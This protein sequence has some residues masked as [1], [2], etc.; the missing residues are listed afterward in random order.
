MAVRCVCLFSNSLS[1]RLKRGIMRVTAG[2]CTTGELEEMA[3][4]QAVREA[5][6]RAHIHRGQSFIAHGRQNAKKIFRSRSRS[7]VCHDMS[8]MT[9][10]TNLPVVL[11]H[12][13]SRHVQPCPFQ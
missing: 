13:T 4:G 9:H 7:V 10:E 2:H 5:G 8:S 6:R 11:C 12:V 3:S 1:K